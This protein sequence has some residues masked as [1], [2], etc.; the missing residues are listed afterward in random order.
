M[1]VTQSFCLYKTV[2]YGTLGSRLLPEFKGKNEEEL[3]GLFSFETQSTLMINIFDEVVEKLD[4]MDSVINLL[5][6][7]AERH[8]QMGISAEVFRK[9][10]EPF[11][12]S[13]K[14]CLGD[15]Y[16]EKIEEIYSIFTK[17]VFDLMCQVIEEGS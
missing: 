16:T 12:I 7:T 10:E 1:S 4:D 6:K 11:T 3:R 17:L 8:R 15:R 9:I 13:L 14:N 5:Q 2:S